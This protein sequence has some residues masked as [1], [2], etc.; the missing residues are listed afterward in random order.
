MEKFLALSHEKQA[1]IRNAALACFARHGYEKTSINDIAVAAG[2][3]GSDHHGSGQH[4]RHRSR[5][6]HHGDRYLR[7]RGR[8]KAPR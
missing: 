1:T 8:K 7:S 5:R 2:S 4:H 3:P 6:G